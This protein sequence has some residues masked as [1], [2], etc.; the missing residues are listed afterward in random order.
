MM[1][2]AQRLGRAQQQLPAGDL[3]GRAG[4]EVLVGLG[5][6]CETPGREVEVRVD[7][8]PSR[9]MVRDQAV[10]GGAEPR[11]EIVERGH[12]RLRVPELERAHVG[13]RVAVACELLLGH[14]D[15]DA[16]RADSAADGTGEG[17]L[18][19]DDPAA[20]P[21]GD[22]CTTR[23]IRR[24]QVLVDHARLDVREERRHRDVDAPEHQLERGQRRDGPAVLDRRHERSREG[25]AE[26]GLG[27]SSSRPLGAQLRSEHET[28]FRRGRCRPAPAAAGVD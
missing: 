11:R 20:L 2:L 1:Q 17:P 7:A 5:R 23:I 9:G 21:R 8:A 10:R 4:R 16:R 14:P 24:G 26:R 13:L 28:P 3:L 6:F 18:V 22:R 15:G 25:C 19:D 12:R 27:Q